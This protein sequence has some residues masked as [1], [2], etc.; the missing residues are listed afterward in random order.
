MGEERVSCANINRDSKNMWKLNGAILF[1]VS[2]SLNAL[3]LV[4][5]TQ[6]IGVSISTTA[7]F[8]PDALAAAGALE[9][10]LDVEKNTVNRKASD[11]DTVVQHWRVSRT[12]P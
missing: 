11:F 4:S 2:F 5:D 1:Q 6:L 9:V 12:Y 7:G 3:T 10:T 8:C